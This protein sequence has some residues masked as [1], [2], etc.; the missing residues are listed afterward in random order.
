MHELMNLTG[1][2][3][4]LTRWSL[5]GNYPGSGRHSLT[6]RSDVRQVRV[7]CTYNADDAWLVSSIFR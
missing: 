6:G 1:Q 3:S 7:L 4:D 2:M 5:V